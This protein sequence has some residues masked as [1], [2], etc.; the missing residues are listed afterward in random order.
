MFGS[1]ANKHLYSL[2]VSLALILSVLLVGG[3]LLPTVASAEDDVVDPSTVTVIE[4]DE[5]ANPLPE[6]SDSE[7]SLPGAELGG[8]ATGIAGLEGLIAPLAASRNGSGNSTQGY[9]H[10]YWGDLSIT[11]NPELPMRC[12]LN[13]G[14]VFDLSNSIGDSG[15]A[16]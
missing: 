7:N 11:P 2:R 6:T 1:L 4:D 8:D 9:T 10:G 3:V 15:L 12:G 5:P 16:V 13:I 14:L